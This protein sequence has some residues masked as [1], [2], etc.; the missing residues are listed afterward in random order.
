MINSI[1]FSAVVE[2]S[3]VPDEALAEVQPFFATEFARNSEKN[4][5]FKFRI[6]N[7]IGLESSLPLQEFNNCNI[8]YE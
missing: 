3:N 7:L 8:L 2:V 4:V 1:V 6:S 5:R